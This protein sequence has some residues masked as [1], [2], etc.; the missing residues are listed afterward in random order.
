MLPTRFLVMVMFAASVL[1]MAAGCG[2]GGGGGGGSPANPVPSP[3]PDVLDATVAQQSGTT[4][5]NLLAEIAR[6]ARGALVL[7]GLVR[8]DAYP[9]GTFQPG[10]RKAAAPVGATACPTI[11][12]VGSDTELTLTFEYGTAPGCVDSFDGVRRSGRLTVSVT[13]IASNPLT[14]IPWSGNVSVSFADFRLGDAAIGG[15]GTIDIVSST[16]ESWKLDLTSSGP[17]DLQHLSFEGVVTAEIETDVETIN[18][19]GLWTSGDLELRA[20]VSD[21]QYDF[22]NEQTSLVCDEPIGGSLTV[23]SNNSATMSF[24]YPQPG[25]GFVNLTIGPTSP[26]RVSIDETAHSDETIDLVLGVV[27]TPVPALVGGH[28]AYTLTVFNAGPDATDVTLT[29]GLS[30]S[31]QWVSSTASQGTCAGSLTVTCHLGNLPHLARAVVTIVGVPTQIGVVENVAS[32]AG[33]LEENLG[34]NTFVVRTL[35]VGQEPEPSGVDLVL[36]VTTSP[37]VAT[38]GQNLTY[39]VTVSNQGQH[40]AT[41]VVV[42]D[43]LSSYG[44][45]WVSSATSQGSCTGNTPVTCTLGSLDAGS[46]ATITIEFTTTYGGTL[47]NSASVSSS[48]QDDVPQNNTVSTNTQV[49]TPVQTPAR[50][51]IT[52][53]SAFALGAG[54]TKQFS[55]T[56]YSD[57]SPYP[58]YYPLVTWTSSDETV[59][60]ITTSGRAT[61]RAA[62]TAT[63]TASTGGVTSNAVTVTVE[64]VRMIDLPTNDLVY[65]PHTQRIYASVPSRA[66]ER[67][68]TVTAIDPTTGTIEWSEFVGS[69]PGKLALSGDGKWLYVGLDGA[70]GVQRFD[71]PNRAL[72]I[73]FSLGR[74]QNYG[75]YGVGDMEV[76]PGQAGSVAVLRRFS[77][78]SGS[79]GVAV[80]DDGVQRPTTTSLFSSISAI[81]FSNVAAT[82]YAF[83]SLT[84][85]TLT[86]D[87]SGVS[88][89]ATTNNVISSYGSD[90][91]FAGGRL[92]FSTGQVVDPASSAVVGTFVLA[93]SNFYFSAVAVEPDSIA[94]RT[95]FLLD[96]NGTHVIKTFDQQTFRPLGTL[97]VQSETQAPFAS[98]TG[99]LRRWGTDGLAFRTNSDQVVLVRPVPVP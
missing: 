42:V 79:A 70:T 84:L 39:T 56:A 99:P 13:E 32:V 9:S 22:L 21:L 87:V 14:F 90:M 12:S 36:D 48:V 85:N 69:E 15:T 27:P 44:A 50:V 2:S 82:L 68:N 55:A 66:G 17:T 16:L 96:G 65:D 10:T 35:V 57:D 46:H 71:V 26:S 88:V 67:G 94:G 76:L 8:P 41:G 43:A 7:Q 34:D 24:A 86:L 72:D 51:E 64:A 63:I 28:V 3:S 60:T 89:S 95:Y 37:A 45:Q 29:D 19:T 75:A 91:R 74:D 61:A 25:C 78:Y 33:G 38:V 73:Q 30:T 80:Y 54:S 49:L 77:P 11:T 20:T 53:A 93:D 58:Q 6:V 40:T 62:G 18:G 1:V 81:A 52:P 92:Y 97:E 47:Y 4:I 31:V 98:P 59:L 83:G 23:A 5:Q